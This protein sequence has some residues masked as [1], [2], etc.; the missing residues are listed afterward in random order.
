[1][2]EQADLISVAAEILREAGDIADHITIVG[3]LAPNLLV[4]DPVLAENH[5]GT[6]DIDFGLAIALDPT[7]AADYTAIESALRKLDFAPRGPSSPSRWMSA[8]GTVIDFLCG[9]P[10]GY[11]E[12]DLVNVT[13]HLAACA[14]PAVPLAALDREKV[15]LPLPGGGTIG[16]W[17]AGVGAFVALKVDAL[18]SRG[19]PRDA[20][21]IVWILRAWSGGPD[22]A[23]A[24][25]ATSEIAQHPLWTGRLPLLRSTFNSP[26]A[27]GAALYGAF[28]DTG[29]DESARR[30][31]EAM[32]TVLA[33]SDALA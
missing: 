16:A 13:E 21:D 25:V 30:S 15:D 22:A 19:K 20:Y 4:P 2:T 14:F 6:T 27:R 17:V 3:G 33:F 1:M 29:A 12:R 31:V 24:T 32:T 11:Q 8:E 7:D 10:R 23:A 18:N 5:V 26:G 28:A 9:I